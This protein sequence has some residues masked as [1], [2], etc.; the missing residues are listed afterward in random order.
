MVYEIQILILY[1][2]LFCFTGICIW[3]MLLYNAFRICVLLKSNTTFVLLM[4]INYM[5]Q[6]TELRNV[7]LFLS[8]IFF[9]SKQ[10]EKIFIT[11][12]SRAAGSV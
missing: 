3:Q 6:Y 7:K 4:P 10:C 9:G 8:F 11:V 2:Q 1:K 12:V 5:N